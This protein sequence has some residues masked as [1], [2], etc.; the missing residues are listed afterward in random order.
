MGVARKRSVFMPPLNH[1]H[2]RYEWFFF[3]KTIKAFVEKHCIKPER[4]VEADEK[5]V[6]IKPKTLFEAEKSRNTVINW[7]N[8]MIVAA[9][10]R[11]LRAGQVYNL[12]RDYCKVIDAEP[13]NLKVFGT[14][15]RHELNIKKR[16]SGTRI[17]YLDIS[18]SLAL[19]SATPDD[20]SRKSLA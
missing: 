7:F 12:Y 5:E 9:P 20:G 10:G 15:M 13:L 19:V 6:F 18:L 4:I 1:F 14:M 2:H 11:S 8:E 17:S 16:G 3:S